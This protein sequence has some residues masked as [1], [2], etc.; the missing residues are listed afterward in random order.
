MPVR[1]VGDDLGV[2]VEQQLRGEFLDLFGWEILATITFSASASRSAGLSHLRRD[3]PQCSAF[4]DRYVVGFVTLD[5]VLGLF[6]R[7]VMCVPLEV[8]IGSNFFDD[9]SADP[10]G[11]GIPPHV[12]T[13]LECFRHH[14]HSVSRSVPRHPADSPLHRTYTADCSKILLAGGKR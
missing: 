6:P 2:F 7:S 8:R 13:S 11:F 9:D 12:V 5:E 14:G 3:H 1:T 4:V 10:S